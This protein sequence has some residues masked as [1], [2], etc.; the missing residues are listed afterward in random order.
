MFGKSNFN[1]EMPKLGL[2][3]NQLF[4]SEFHLLNHVQKGFGIPKIEI[5]FPKPDP[6]KM[7]IGNFKT[8]WTWVVCQ[9]YGCMKIRILKIISPHC[10][11]LHPDC[12]EPEFNPTA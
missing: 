11:H 4:I 6:S 9:K 8:F 2:D 5:G 7:L 1:L 10:V 12:I 3:Q